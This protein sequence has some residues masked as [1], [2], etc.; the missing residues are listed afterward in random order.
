[1]LAAKK[2]VA[3]ARRETSSAVKNPTQRAS[4]TGGGKPPVIPPEVFQLVAEGDGDW[5]SR[6]TSDDGAKNALHEWGSFIQLA[7]N[8]YYVH[9]INRSN[10]PHVKRPDILLEG[11]DTEVKA[12]LGGITNTVNADLRGARI[13]SSQIIIDCHRTELSAKDIAIY[14]KR[15]L[16]RYSEIQRVMV[17]DGETEVWITNE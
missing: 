5:R 9:V 16:A 13:Q 3:T 17:L 11:V 10:E 7:R 4:G 8:G 2:R 1:M 12:P 6:L 15:A 14:S